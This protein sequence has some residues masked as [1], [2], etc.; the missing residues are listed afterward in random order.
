LSAHKIHGAKGVGALWIRRGIDLG[1]LHPGGH[2]ERG[3]RPGTEDVAAIVGF[4]EATRIAREEGLADA[5][6]IAALRDRLE[7][8]CLAVEG[9][10]GYGDR[11]ARVPNT[12]NVAFA[13]AP[14]ELVVIALDLEGVAASTGAA[15]TSGRVEPSAVVLALGEPR[16]RAAEAVRFSLGRGTT[17][18]EI[19]QVVALLPTIVSRIRAAGVR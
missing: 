12:I 6:R 8:G 14:G 5:P 15:C 2:Q 3:L 13:G 9:A 19:D 17:T 4:G 16:E 10:R 11:S 7:A 1:P 18:E